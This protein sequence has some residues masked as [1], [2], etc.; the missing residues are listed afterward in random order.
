MLKKHAVQCEKYILR[1]PYPEKISKLIHSITF[2]SNWFVETEAGVSC[3]RLRD[4]EEVLEGRAISGEG[5]PMNLSFHE[6]QRES[7]AVSAN[8]P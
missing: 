5:E 8:A 4:C 1:V 7:Q 3:V 6:S 2:K